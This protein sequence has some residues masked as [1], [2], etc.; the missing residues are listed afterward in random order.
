MITGESS[1]FACVAL[2]GVVSVSSL[3]GEGGLDRL[4]STGE[5]IAY[6]SDLSGT[7]SGGSADR[8]GLRP[9]NVDLET[10]ESG[11]GAVVGMGSMWTDS[12]SC[13]LTEMDESRL[14]VTALFMLALDRR[15]GVADGPGVPVEL[16]LDR[17]L[18]CPFEVACPAEARS[19]PSRTNASRSMIAYFAFFSASRCAWL[20]ILMAYFLG[21]RGEDVE[22]LLNEDV[23]CTTCREHCECESDITTTYRAVTSSSQFFAQHEVLQ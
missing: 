11:L 8:L 15:R 20:I 5:S 17:P 14:A 10:G 12:R 7:I 4:A 19:G 13:G 3:T 1:I 22:R 2:G 18:R 9:A 6:S 16:E 23:A 21:G